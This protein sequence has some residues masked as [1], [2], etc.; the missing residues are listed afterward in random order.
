MSGS[1]HGALSLANLSAALQIDS[2]ALPDKGGE[3][4][5]VAKQSIITRN[6]A[7]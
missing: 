4:K 1:L 2:A 6:L 7:G 3:A 5:C